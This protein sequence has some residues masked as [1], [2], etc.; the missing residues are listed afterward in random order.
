MRFL[1][2]DF[3]VRSFPGVFACAFLVLLSVRFSAETFCV[4]P[5]AG[6]SA[7]RICTGAFN[8][9]LFCEAFSARAFA[10]LFRGIFHG[11]IFFA[12]FSMD[13]F[14]GVFR[15]VIFRLLSRGKH[16]GAIFLEAFSVHF[17]AGEISM[18]SFTG[19][20]HSAIFCRG[21]F[22]ELFL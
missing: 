5:I 15:T 8:R 19:P 1:S 3:C 6:V 17:F 16:F 13:G 18:D 20:F 22:H 12:H 4:C 11:C 14:H 7:V 2:V 9:V 21:E 10:R